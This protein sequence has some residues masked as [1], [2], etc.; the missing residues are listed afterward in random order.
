MMERLLVE[1]AIRSVFV[2]VGVAGVLWATRMKAPAVLHAMWTLVMLAMLLLPL[3]T[4]WGPK[5]AMPMLPERPASRALPLTTSMLPTTP[6]RPQ[7]VGSTEPR[8]SQAGATV[9]RGWSWQGVAVLVYSIVASALLTRL[10]IG[11]LRARRLVRRAI[12]RDGRLTSAACASPVTVGWLRPV[13]ILPETWRD[14]S[15]ARLDAVLAHE[16][17]HVRRRDPLVQW[18]ALLNRAM[19]WFHPLAW[20]LERRLSGLAEQTCDEAVLACGHDPQAYS[21]YLI[22]A[23]RALGREG[24]THL[25]GAFMPGACLPE[26]IARI[27]D[28]RPIVRVSRLR[29]ASTVAACVIA[30]IASAVAMPVRAA[31][32]RAGQSSRLI[33]RPLQPRWIPP[34]SNAPQPVSL[35]WLDGDEWAFEVQSIITNEELREYSELQRAPERD[36]FIARFWARR[37]PSPGT[38][39]NEFRDEFSRR[40]RFA[41]ETLA[42]PQSHGTPGFDTDRGLVYLMFGQ[43]DAI[44]TQKSDAEQIVVW[45]YRDI[46]DIGA[47]FIVR[48]SSV[49]GPYCGFRIVSPA[50]LARVE[51]AVTGSTDARVPHTFV[52]FYPF[53]L[54]AVSVPVDA[55]RVVGAGWELRNQN[56]NQVDQGSIGFLEGPLTAGTLSQHLSRAWLDVGLGCTYALPADVY[57]LTTEVRVASGQVQRESVTFELP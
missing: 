43:P 17:A 26:R 23:A 14:W 49:R 24:R 56:G 18:L 54:T 55:A 7:Q 31:A 21:E 46:A 36:A 16:H 12:V 33:V 15:S 2:A 3:W 41:R 1:S 48:F 5:A 45:R 20:W 53:G 34:D 9:R 22:D 11:T 39:I 40:V 6:V 27:L 32:Q 29:A 38:P 35:E 47:D 30:L 50:P 19:F 28:G 4:V 57:T 25:A 42:D 52:Q 44:E 51:A 8:S 37:D 10:A 13:V